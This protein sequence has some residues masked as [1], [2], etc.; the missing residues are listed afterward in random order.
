MMVL[1][2]YDVD[3]T[4]YSGQKRLSKVAKTCVNFGQRVQKSVFECV[5]EPQQ[6]V[7]IKA[8]LSKLIDAD[9]D[10]I[11]LYNL[12]SNWKTRIEHIG[13]GEPYDPEG[14]LIT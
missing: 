13:S 8:K 2:T 1:I 5:L 3:T 6:Y 10:S 11:R 4:T 12:G 9:K 7:E 14:V